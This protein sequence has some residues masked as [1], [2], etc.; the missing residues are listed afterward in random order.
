MMYCPKCEKLNK[1]NCKSCNPTGEIKDVVILDLKN[2]LYQCYFCH[3]K[4]SESECMDYEWDR[5]VKD[6]ADNISPQECLDWH[7]STPRDKKSIE[8]KSGFGEL[9]YTYAFTTHFQKHPNTCDKPTALKL[10]R[11]LSLKNI[12]NDE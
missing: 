8:K 1:C 5:M 7:T 11:D 4:F 9:G 12:L 3:Y 2:K 6:F 10:Q